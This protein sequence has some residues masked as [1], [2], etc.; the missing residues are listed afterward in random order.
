MRFEI[1]CPALV[2]ENADRM[3]QSRRDRDGFSD[4]TLRV[5]S[6]DA[7]QSSPDSS[8]SFALHRIVLASAAPFFAGL[9]QSLSVEMPAHAQAAIADGSAS[10]GSN[11]TI[12]LPHHINVAHVDA[13]LEFCYAGRV[14][15]EGEIATVLALIE[16]ADMFGVEVRRRN[17]FMY[18]CS[19]QQIFWAEL[20]LFFILN[21]QNLLTSAC[22]RLCSMI[23]I[24]C[25]VSTLTF[26]GRFDDRR[27]RSVR[28][29][30]IA[31][32]AQ[33]LVELCPEPKADDIVECDQDAFLAL[34]PEDLLHVLDH[35][36]RIHCSDVSIVQLPEF[37]ASSHR[38][39]L[40]PPV[41]NAN[42]N[43]Q[44]LA[45]SHAHAIAHAHS[46][47]ASALADDASAYSVA[48]GAHTG[49]G[50]VLVASLAQVG[51]S[52]QD[53]NGGFEAAVIGTGQSHKQLRERDDRLLRVLTTC[54]AWLF[55]VSASAE[56]SAQVFALLPP[57]E[58]AD[59]VE[60]RENESSASA[61]S[62]DLSADSRHAIARLFDAYTAHTR[63]A[64]I[65]SAFRTVAVERASRKL[66]W[67]DMETSSASSGKHER[68][69]STSPKRSAMAC[70]DPLEFAAPLCSHALSEYTQQS[71]CLAV[72]RDPVGREL[73]IAGIG[74]M[75][76]FWRT[77]SWKFVHST[78]RCEF[79]PVCQRSDV[80]L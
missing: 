43:A 56:L 62:I 53:G 28:A 59:S 54:V 31:F 60:K 36:A 23:D 6:H 70:C 7:A 38:V 48:I 22:E 40:T 68:L 13:F 55:H 24:H 16:L 72:A 71:M 67:S 44:P 30:V 65:A 32:I 58:L 35:F 50:R 47:T 4:F 1:A 17:L 18:M 20:K 19:R 2:R 39:T 76:R 9:F 37:A 34:A 29:R 63:Y 21:S 26:L 79:I 33:H 27:I 49:G 46:S 14:Q 78:Q 69:S 75:L 52:G 10:H 73:L 41:T 42:V 3:R 15:F 74:A 45:V 77:D 57:L 64:A 8:T 61:S 5:I 11:M 25:C 66:G 80:C 51:R 12:E